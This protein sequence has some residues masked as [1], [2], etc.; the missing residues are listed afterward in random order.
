MDVF[1]II[2]VRAKSKSNKN[3]GQPC[4]GLLWMRP[5]SQFII[6]GSSASR[7]L[8]GALTP[9]SKKRLWMVHLII[10]S[11][12]R[13]VEF[14]WCL[15]LL[16]IEGSMLFFQAWSQIALPRWEDANS[17]FSSIL[18]LNLMQATVSWL[19]IQETSGGVSQRCLIACKWWGLILPFTKEDTSHNRRPSN[20]LKRIYLKLLERKVLY[21]S[22]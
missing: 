8:E 2:H 17:V 9:R 10:W 20:T 19:K 15:I 21:L 18:M 12:V 1:L 16:C 4:P 6:Y 5:D 22:L 7:V 13:N 14:S 3:C 11:V